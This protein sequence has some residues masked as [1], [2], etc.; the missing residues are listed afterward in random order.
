MRQKGGIMCSFLPSNY[1]LSKTQS[2]IT[3]AFNAKGLLNGKDAKAI[4]AGTQPN[5]ILS[6]SDECCCSVLLYFLH[7]VDFYYFIFFAV[8]FLIIFRY[9]QPFFFYSF[10]LGPLVIYTFYKGFL[11][12]WFLFVLLLS[13]NFNV[14]A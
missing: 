14:S 9:F 12:F 4:F 8:S 13:C 6:S 10:F 7:S 1:Y 2:N 11:F 5:L 3:A